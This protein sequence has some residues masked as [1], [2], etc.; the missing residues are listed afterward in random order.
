LLLFCL[1][2]DSLQQSVKGPA[3]AAFVPGLNGNCI[4]HPF[5]LG[6]K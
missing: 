4:V 3:A 2:I 1:N 6:T 5:V